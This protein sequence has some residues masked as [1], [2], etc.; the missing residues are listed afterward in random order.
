MKKA[1]VSVAIIATGVIASVTN[2]SAQKGTQL[3]VEGT[4]HISW[5]FNQDDKDN[6]QFKSINTFGAS[7]G[8]SGQYNFTESIGIGL[9]ALYSFQ[10][11]RYELGGVERIKKLEYIKVPVLFVFSSDIN[12]DFL[13]IGKIGPQVGFLVN[14]KLTDKDGDNIVGNQKSAYENLNI[15]GLVYAGIGYRLTDNLC[16]D[17][18]LK[19]EYGI[20]DAENKE[21]TKNINNPLSATFDGS[22]INNREITRTSTAGIAIGLRYLFQ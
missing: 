15:E 1:V 18:S 8:V 19:F 12:S 11:Q 22:G 17:A 9:N 3:G 6:N 5:L 16:L 2:A 21:Y 4:P 13:F 7:F 14:A 20:T 10:G